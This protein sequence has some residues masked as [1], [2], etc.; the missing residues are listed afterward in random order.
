MLPLLKV[1]SVVQTF[2]LGSLWA[3][4]AIWEQEKKFHQQ[5]NGLRCGTAVECSQ[6]LFAQS[7]N[8]LGH[9]NLLCLKKIFG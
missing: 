4:S 9:H 6:T 1:E 2:A 3:I 5:W 7:R 8:P